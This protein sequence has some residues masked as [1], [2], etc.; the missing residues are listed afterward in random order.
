[1]DL[2]L[3]SIKLCAVFLAIFRPAALVALGCFFLEFGVAVLLLLLLLAGGL[4][5]SLGFAGDDVG[6]GEL[7]SLGF[8]WMIFRVRVGGG[9]RLN[10]SNVLFEPAWRGGLEVRLMDVD[11]RAGDGGDTGQYDPTESFRTDVLGRISPFEGLR[12][13]GGKANGGSVISTPCWSLTTS[14]PDIEGVR[15]RRG[16]DM[17]AHSP[18]GEDLCRNARSQLVTRMLSREMLLTTTVTDLGEEKGVAEWSLGG[19]S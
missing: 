9:G 16:R 2:R 4:L 12:A 18:G 11:A 5:V 10:S 8:I 14:S 13:A 17:L 3:R 7:E 19:W 6:F 15:G 1:M